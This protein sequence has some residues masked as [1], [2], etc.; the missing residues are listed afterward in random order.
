MKRIQVGGAQVEGA[1]AAGGGGGAAESVKAMVLGKRKDRGDNGTYHRVDWIPP[2]S[3]ICER[4][5]SQ[6]K[7]VLGLLRQSMSP[8]R[9]NLLLFLKANRSYWDMQVVG[10]AMARVTRAEL[11]SS[12][13]APPIIALEDDEE[14]EE[15]EEGDEGDD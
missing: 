4:I 7:L 5:F 15:E 3:N 10:E 9:L 13:G 8:E 6:A 2:T 1:A 14:E 12:G 11:A